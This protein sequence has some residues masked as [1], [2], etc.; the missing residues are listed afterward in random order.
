LEKYGAF[1]YAE[2]MTTPLAE[3]MRDAIVKAQQMG[4]LYT[5]PDATRPVVYMALQGKLLLVALPPCRAMPACMLLKTLFAA[6]GWSTVRACCCDYA[7]SGS[8]LPH[9]GGPA[10]LETDKCL[11]LVTLL[12][13]TGEMSAT[14]MRYTSDWSQLIPLVKDTIG[15]NFADVKVG[16]GLNYNA[17]EAVEGTA[18]TLGSAFLDALLSGAI[19]A[20]TNASAPVIQVNV[21][22]VLLTEKLDF[23]GVSAYSPFSGTDFGINEFQNAATS[24]TQ[25]LA[26]IVGIDI[27]NLVKA[28][29][30]DLIYSRFGIG[31]GE[32]WMAQLAEAAEAC[33][34]QPWAGVLGAYSTF[35]DPWKNIYLGAFRESFFAKALAWLVAPTDGTV[36][37]SDV[38]VWSLSSWDI[39]GIYPDSTSPAGSFR[40]LTIVKQVAHY[41]T[42]VMAAQICRMATTDVCN[43][44]C[45]LACIMV[46]CASSFFVAV[47]F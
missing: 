13:T 40:D 36:A 28:G 22:K 12:C 33:A 21:L 10:S 34:Q 41:N 5:P 11:A 38:F 31:G 43:V 14:L 3:A 23:L 30:L 8:A 9:V 46:C 16:A 25:A 45:G 44:S 1:S 6:P 27:G 20:P 37:V 18:T 35:L 7:N 29:K 47:R 39:F 42:A 17:L 24:I 2:V 32:N 26:S 19:R 4:K 15:T